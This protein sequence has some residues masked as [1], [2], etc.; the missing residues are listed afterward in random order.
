M[1][2]TIGILTLREDI[3]AVAV[4]RSIE[5]RHPATCHII[6]GKEL[7]T[8][9]GLSWSGDS[10]APSVLRDL[11]GE[12]IEVAKLDAMWLRR[13]AIRQILPDEADPKYSDEIHLSCWTALQGHLITEFR[14]AWVSDPVATEL[15]ENKVLQLRA[16]R[17][18]GLRIPATLVSQDPARI[19]AFCA[20]YPAAII[21]PIRTR[22]ELA[23]TAVASAELL[24]HDEVLALS[25][26]IYQENVPGD[27]HLRITMFGEQ[28]FA[29]LIEARELDW[30]VDVTVPFSPYEPSAQLLQALQSVLRSLG[31]VMGIFD[32]KLTPDGDIVFFEVNP[33]G[34]FL[35]VE[36][37]CE[38]PIAR[39]LGDYLVE[40]ACE[41][42]ISPRSAPALGRQRPQLTAMG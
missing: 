25:P 8:K 11:S 21:K 28:C 20:A 26:A 32:L 17:R 39:S 4:K 34:Q 27:R 15:A 16:A 13:T 7:A 23:I 41:S 35:F 9:G 29:A 22:G 40:R 42:A 37:L 31:L 2:V 33:Q 5:E 10:D 14:G 3:H 30:R 36:G 6:A 18:A 38:M 12:L 24:Q 19:R 1:N